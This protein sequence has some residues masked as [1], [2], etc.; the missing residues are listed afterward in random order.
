MRYKLSLEEVDDLLLAIHTTLGI[1][2]EK[3]VL[4]HNQMYKGL[5]EQKKRVFLIHFILISCHQENGKKK[6]NL[7]FQRR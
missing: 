6:G 5:G 4:L 3:K 7:Y 1:Q 2:E